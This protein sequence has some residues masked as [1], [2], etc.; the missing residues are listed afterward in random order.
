MSLYYFDI[1]DGEFMPD[2]TGTECAN[3][4]AVREHAKRVLPAIAAETLPEHGDH[5]TLIVRV[6]NEQHE[7]V[8]TATL[9][10]NGLTPSARWPE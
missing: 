7:T 1:L 2:E 8:Y 3:L 4:Q 5:Q 10:F 6:R 9:S